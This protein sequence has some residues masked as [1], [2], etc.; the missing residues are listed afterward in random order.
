MQTEIQAAEPLEPDT[1]DSEFQMAI[2]KLKCHKPPGT[3][4]T[5][6]PRVT[7]LSCVLFVGEC[8]LDNCHRDI[9]PLFDYPN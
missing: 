2:E 1:G 8:V 5:Y 7:V 6:V 4:Q 9:G 3:D